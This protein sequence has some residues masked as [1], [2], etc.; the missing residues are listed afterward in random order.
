M[1][2]TQLPEHRFNHPEDAAAHVSMAADYYEGMFGARPAG[3]WPGEGAVAQEIVGTVADAGFTWMASDDQVLQ[4]SLGA[5]YLSARDRYQMYWAEESGKRVAMI[6]RDHRLSDDIGFNFGKMDGVDAAN[7]MMRSLHSIHKQLADDERAYVVP[8][9]LD[10]ENAWEW[11]RHDG[12][13]FFHSWYD[14][15]G[16]ASFLTTVTVEDFLAEHPPTD[17]ASAPVGGLVDQARTSPRGSVSP[18]RTRRGTTWRSCA[19]TSTAFAARGDVRRR[20]ARARVRRDVRGGGQRLVLV[21]RDRPGVLARRRFRQD[22]PRN[23]RP[24]STRS[25]ERRRPRSCPRAC[26][27]SRRPP[28]PAAEA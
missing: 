23:A 28:P 27:W 2:G 19:P 7:S 8:I 16:R 5:P 24:T 14:Q 17:D 10:G 9:I 13:E 21:V 22:L 6:F 15:L 1:P 3:L 18:R 20:R 25:S 12:K 4:K 26:C 11:Y